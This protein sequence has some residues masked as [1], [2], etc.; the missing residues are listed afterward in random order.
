MRPSR[1]NV[2]VIAALLLLALS[3]CSTTP[4]RPA[5]AGA[6][7]AVDAA[8]QRSFERGVALLNAQ[9]YEAASRLFADMTERYPQYPEPYVN[10]AVAYQH[11]DRADDAEQALR[12]A[13]EAKPGSAQAHTELAILYRRSGQFA[14]AREHYAIALANRPDYAP[15]HLNMGILCDLYLQE[16]E[17]ALTHYQRYQELVAQEDAQVSRWI[18]DLE[19]R[20][21]FARES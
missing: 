18:V 9:D 11:L 17:C 8:V 14:E 4:Q 12:K 2:F 20:L 13:L 7:S 5:P 19:K 10:L 16:L 15:A 21:K 1:L 3:A 6:T